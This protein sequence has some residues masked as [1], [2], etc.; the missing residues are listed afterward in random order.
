MWMLKIESVV[1]NVKKYLEAAILKGQLAPGQQIKEQ[2]VSSALGI[3]RPPIREALK[4]LE[5]EGLIIRKPNRG[6][7]VSE[8]TGKDI[9]EIYTLKV[10]LYELATRL[11][12]HKISERTIKRWESIVQ[13]MEACINKRPA[14]LFKYQTL[15]ESFHDVMFDLSGHERLKKIALTLHNQVKPFSFRSLGEEGHLKESFRFH[16]EI[17]EALKH[18]DEERAVRLTR[19]HV[20]SGLE[21]ARSRLGEKESA[22]DPRLAG[23]FLDGSFHEPA[24]EQAVERK[25]I[26]SGGPGEGIPLESTERSKYSH[27][28]NHERRK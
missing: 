27:S 25:G 26:T 22:S 4:I 15:N 13:Q 24:L 18:R 20:F 6:A 1:D 23:A 21:V 11:A 16:S 3:S 14:D 7:F 10:S 17:L 28:F 8:I 19:E 2:E 9:W 5:A 12:F